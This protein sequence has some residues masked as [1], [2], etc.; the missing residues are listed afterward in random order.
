MQAAWTINPIP[1]TPQ[2]QS[3]HQQYFFRSNQKS[4]PL[5]TTPTKVSEEYIK[6]ELTTKRVF[7]TQSKN[8]SYSNS[9]TNIC[10]EPIQQSHHASKIVSFFKIT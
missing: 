1:S 5:Q 6:K 3:I 10:E 9:K 8:S 7:L 4:P 2:Q